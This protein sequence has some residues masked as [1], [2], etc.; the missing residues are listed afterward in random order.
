MSRKKYKIVFP[1]ASK[2][3]EF[4]LTALENGT[5][6]DGI[7]EGLGLKVLEALGLN[8]N[9]ESTVAILLHANSSKSGFKDLIKVQRRELSEEDYQKIIEISP[10]ARM[11]IIKEYNVLKKYLPEKLKT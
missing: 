7:E 6:I 10:Y 3:P 11:S 1:D 2:K 8:K 5:V 9:L 4:K